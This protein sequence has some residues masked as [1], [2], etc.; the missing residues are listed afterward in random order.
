MGFLIIC[1]Y[2]VLYVR[3]LLWDAGLYNDGARE[4]ES[5]ENIFPI[6]NYLIYYVLILVN[7]VSRQ[8]IYLK[9]SET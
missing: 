1:L 9:I 5:Y 8:V 3:N 7:Y 2:F 4:R 6:K